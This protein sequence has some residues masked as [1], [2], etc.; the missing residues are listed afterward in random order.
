[1]TEETA[2]RMRNCGRESAQ[3][4][5]ATAVKTAENNEQLNNQMYCAYWIAIHILCT[6][7]LNAKEQNN[8]NLEA[9]VKEIIRDLE[10][11]NDFL[12]ENAIIEKVHFGMDA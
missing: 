10:Q 1:M 11:E 6:N 5:L 8:I 9:F 7:A 3:N 4:L 12:K 2:S